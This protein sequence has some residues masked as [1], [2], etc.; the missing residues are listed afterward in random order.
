MRL[1]FFKLSMVTGYA[2]GFSALVGGMFSASG[3]VFS[4]DPSRSSL[5]LSGSILGYAV[6][7]QGAGSLTAAYAG[8]IQVSQAAGTIQFTGGSLIT[9]ETNGSWQPLPGG[10]SGSAPAD[11]GGVATSEFET[12][13]A[14]LRSIL[15]DVTSPPLTVTSGQFNASSLTFLF[16]SNA[17]S[18]IDYRA[19]G[20]FSGSGSKAATGNSTNNVVTLATITTVGDTET[21]TLTVNVQF[22]FTLVESGDTIVKLAGQIVATNSS[23]STPPVLQTPTV[24]KQA[25]TLNWTGPAEQF[26]QVMSSSN[27]MTWQTNASNVTSATTNYTWT[28]TN[29]DSQGF[30]RLLQ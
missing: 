2:V 10:S 30:Y 8:S 17:T 26:Y 29:S 3:N 4:I 6:S 15:L 18:A 22:T 24:T 1:S 20:L 19:S 12:A 14:A 21:L 13:Y 11:Y 23:A 9:A 7:P 5:T 16:P 27:M 28:V 25:I